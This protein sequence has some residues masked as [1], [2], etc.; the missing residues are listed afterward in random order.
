MFPVLRWP[1]VADHD[2]GNLITLCLLSGNLTLWIHH[3]LHHHHHHLND[4]V[5]MIIV[6]NMTKKITNISTRGKLL[7]TIN[8]FSS[9]WFC[10]TSSQSRCEQLYFL[11][12]T[13]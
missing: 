5:I 7:L 10:A 6:T 9:K 8:S 2:C 11:P 4:V 3:H 12:S 13:I 1:T